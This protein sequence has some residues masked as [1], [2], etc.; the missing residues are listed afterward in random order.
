MEN[1]KREKN[2]AG[3]VGATQSISKLRPIL[4]P[5]RPVSTVNSFSGGK[6]ASFFFNRTCDSGDRASR[7]ND[8]LN[9]LL[10]TGSPLRQIVDQISGKHHFYGGL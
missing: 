10:Y 4:T 6:S 8:N 7:D 9:D 3:F 5:G 2:T 1:L